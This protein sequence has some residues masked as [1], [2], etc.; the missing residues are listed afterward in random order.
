MCHADQQWTEALSLVLIIIHPLF[1]ANLQASVAD[2]VLGEYL[3]IPGELLTPAHLVTQLRQHMASL[4]LV[5][6]SHHAS[7]ATFVHKDLHN[8][9]H[10]FLHQETSHRALEPCEHHFQPLSQRNPSHSTTDYTAIDS[11]YP[12]YTFW[13]LPLMLQHLSNILR[14]GG[15]GDVRNLWQSNCTPSASLRVTCCLANQRGALQCWSPL[16]HAQLKGRVL[17]MG[18]RSARQSVD[19]AVPLPRGVNEDRPASKNQESQQA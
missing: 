19:S 8:C 12:D 13:P 11:S 5:L 14:P 17:K 18:I 1:K 15:G 2:L 4:G 3:R 10:V 9:T 16:A 7:P 6:A